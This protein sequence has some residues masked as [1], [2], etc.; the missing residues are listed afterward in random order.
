MSQ[1]QFAIRGAVDV[2]DC[3]SSDSATDITL[4]VGT[5]DNLAVIGGGPTN[6]FAE[7]NEQVVLWAMSSMFPKT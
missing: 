5:K 4:V 2:S 1:H 3:Q 6:V 7:K